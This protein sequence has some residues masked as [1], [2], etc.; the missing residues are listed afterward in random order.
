MKQFRN[1]TKFGSLIPLRNDGMFQEDV[2]EPFPVPF[3]NHG[4]GAR[5]GRNAAHNH[6]M[7]EK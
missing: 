6:V 4:G 1:I 7:G 2:R 3:D 5:N